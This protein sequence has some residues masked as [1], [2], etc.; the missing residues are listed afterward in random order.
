LDRFLHALARAINI[1]TRIDI[2]SAALLATRYAHGSPHDCIANCTDERWEQNNL[3]RKGIRVRAMEN[4]S[5]SKRDRIGV[6]RR[7]DVVGKRFC[8]GS[9]VDFGHDQQTGVSVGFE[10]TV[11]P[12]ADYDKGIV[13]DRLWFSRKNP[14][15]RNKDRRRTC[16]DRTGPRE[17][18]LNVPRASLVPL[19]KTILRFYF[20]LNCIRDQLLSFIVARGHRKNFLFVRSGH[21]HP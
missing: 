14:R 19:R 4:G 1:S 15:A 17:Y 6:R 11:N 21:L 3:L 5:R 13:L 18:F 20:R 7:D 2:I 12:I 16:N 10:W 8:N 9:A